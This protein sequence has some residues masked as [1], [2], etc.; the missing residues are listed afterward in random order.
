MDAKAQLFLTVSVGAIMLTMGLG[1]TPDDFLRVGSRPRAVVVGLVGQLVLL[2]ALAFA[3]AFGFGLPPQLAL[4]LVLI[5]ACPG[6]AHSNLYASFAKADTALSVTLTALSGIVT[7]VTIPLLLTLGIRVFA[8]DGSIPPMPIGATMAQI[9]LVMGLP[10]ALGMGVRARSERWAGRLERP[11]KGLATLLLVLIVVGSLRGHGERL[12]AAMVSSGAAVLTL[13]LGSMALG[14]GLAR[15]AAL[16]VPQQL[17]VALE[18]GI[19]NGTLAFVLGLSL[20]GG[21]L[22]LLPPVFLYS[23]VV[24]PTGAVVVLI[25]RALQR[26]APGVDASAPDANASAPDEAAS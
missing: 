14:W 7:I 18:V 21:D 19:Q 25:G 12:S 5:A 22:G 1:L 17:T 3:C 20:M 15:A 23:L 24:Y 26:S 4:G 2:P 10:V 6:G 13:N 11:I 8:A 16:P 9:F